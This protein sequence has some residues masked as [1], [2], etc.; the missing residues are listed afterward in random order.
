MFAAIIFFHNF[1]RAC[2]IGSALLSNI[3]MVT[4]SFVTTKM[5]LKIVI[6]AK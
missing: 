2:V 3:V 4:M 5:S 1:I 6:A